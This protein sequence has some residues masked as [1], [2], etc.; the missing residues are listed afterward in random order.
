MKPPS[1]LRPSETRL[2]PLEIDKPM[3]TTHNTHSQMLSNGLNHHKPS[4]TSLKVPGL[5]QR[6]DQRQEPQLSPTKRR[7]IL[8][9]LLEPLLPSKRDS[10]LSI[11][12]WLLRTSLMIPMLPTPRELEFQELDKLNFKE[13]WTTD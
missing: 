12:L 6:L 1:K 4:L 3:V 5:N 13:V 9:T 10:W 11:T 7:L 2:V 8:L